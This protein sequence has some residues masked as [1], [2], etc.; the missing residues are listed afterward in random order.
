MT[1]LGNRKLCMRNMEAEGIREGIRVLVQPRIRL[2][3]P[4]K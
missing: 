1:D 2:G 4:N 3:L